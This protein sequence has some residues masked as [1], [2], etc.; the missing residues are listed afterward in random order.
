MR[1]YVHGDDI[2]NIDWKVTARTKV[3]HT[4]VFT[5][6]KERPAFMI[7]DQSSSMFFASEGAMKSVLAAQI[8]AIGGFK[9]LKSG[10][11]L[12]L[13]ISKSIID[14]FGG[15]IWF[16]SE[17]GNPQQQVRHRSAHQKH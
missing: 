5:E 7:V 9:V 17:E 13:S 10:V 3:T 14:K 4:K 8:A 11:G 1:K 2:R 16:E 6:E 15:E 12:G